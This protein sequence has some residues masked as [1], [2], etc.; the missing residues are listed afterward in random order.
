MTDPIEAQNRWMGH[1]LVLEGGAVQ[2]PQT[3][4]PHQGIM[5]VRNA[6][7]PSAKEKNCYTPI[8]NILILNT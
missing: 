3:P 4:R 2:V 5:D 8:L 6:T 1:S 7:Q